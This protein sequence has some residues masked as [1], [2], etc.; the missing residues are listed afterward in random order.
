MSE[1][2]LEIEELERLQEWLAEEATDYFYDF[3]RVFLRTKVWH[4]DDVVRI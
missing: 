2:K 4:I 1:T 3:S